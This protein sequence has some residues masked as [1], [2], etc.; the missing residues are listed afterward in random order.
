MAKSKAGPLA[1]KR[2]PEQKF[3]PITG[4]SKAMTGGQ[5]TVKTVARPGGP[6]QKHTSKVAAGQ[7]F[8]AR[9]G[10]SQPK[11]GKSV[12]SGVVARPGGSQPSDGESATR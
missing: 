5:K 8:T 6:L 12:G 11:S 10:G 9:P 7:G 2:S 4:R 3:A 1:G